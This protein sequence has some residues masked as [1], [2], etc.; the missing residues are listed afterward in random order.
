MAHYTNH[1]F[2]IDELLTIDQQ[3]ED[4]IESVNI[5]LSDPDLQVKDLALLL[6]SLEIMDNMEH[7]SGYKDFIIG[8]AEKSS[9][10]VT[11][12]EMIENGG[13]DKTFL[14]DNLVQNA[15]FES[16]A[17]EFEIAKASNFDVG[18]DLAS[19]WEN[20][21]AYKFDK[22]IIEGTTL[23]SAVTDGLQTAVSGF[24]VAL[25]PN[26]QYK[27]EYDLLVN[28]VNWDL[29]NGGKNLVDVPSE[30]TTIFSETGGGPDPQTYI[31][32]VI[33]DVNLVIPTCT[34][35]A[36]TI[37][38]SIITELTC[39]E[40]NA[41]WDYNPSTASFFCNDPNNLAPGATTTEECS[42]NNATWDEGAL[43]DP[44]TQLHTIVP[45][46]V[47]AREGDTIIFTNP[48]GNWLLHNAVSDDNISF[49]SP[50]LQP[51]ED[52]SWVVDG[53]HD[54]YFHCTFHPLEEGRLSTTT[55]HR[56]VYNVGHG[57]NTGDTIRVPINYGAMV[58][59]PNLANSYYI[60]ISMTNNVSSI[61]GAGSQTV[62]ESLYHDLSLGDLVT[63]QSGEV[64]DD[65]DSTP[66]VL[67]GFIG[68]NDTPALASATIAAGSISAVTLVDGGSG[69]TEAP[70]ILIEG[71]GG[72]GA[73]AVATYS[74][75]I[76]S[77]ALASG[78]GYT[79]TPSISF[80]G[81]NPEVGAVATAVLGSNVVSALVI[82]TAGAGYTSIP[83]VTITG[84][85]AVQSATATAGIDFASGACSDGITAD[86]TEC[87]T[88]VCSNGIA[89]TEDLCAI[90][91]CSN[92]GAEVFA[93][94]G[95]TPLN[96]AQCIVEICSDPTYTDEA[97]CVAALANWA[98]P[99][100]WTLA[101]TWAAPGT[102]TPSD[103]TLVSIAIINSGDQY[104]T[105]PTVTITGG[106]ASVDA[107]VSA[108]IGAP[109]DSILLN[110][111]GVGYLSTPSIEFT[112]GNPTFAGSASA[113]MDGSVDTLTLTAGGTGYGSATGEVS[114]GERQW[115]TYVIDAV[116]KGS[117]RVDVYFNDVNQIGH[118]HTAM[119]T[120]AQYA[121][122]QTGTPTQVSTISDST[123]HEHVATFD[124]DPAINDGAG[125]LLLVGM[126][127]G[128]THGLNEYFEISG[129][130][131]VELVNFGHYH[132]ILINETDE[133]TLKANLIVPN[134]TNGDG[135][136]AHDGTGTVM[137]RTSDFGTSD[138]Q[139]FHTVEFGCV[140]AV[141]D[142]YA[143]TV[144]DQHIHDFGRVWYPGSDQFTIGQYDNSYN[145]GDDLNP[146][147]IANPFTDIPGFVKK[148]R[149]ILSDDHGLVPGDRV[150]FENVYN[151]I[152]HGNT[153]Y[154]ID[155]V[156][157][158]DSFVLTETVVY[159]LEN[160]PGTTPSTFNVIEE[161][162]VAADLASYRFQV[163]RDLTN[164]IGDSVA[165][166]GVQLFWS[167]PNAVYS[168]AHGLNIGDVVQLPSGPQQYVPSEI[169]GALRDHTVVGLGD[170]YGPTEHM[171][172]TV[173]TQ[174][175]ITHA[176][177][178][179]PTQ[180]G[181][182]QT[183]WY[184]T[185]WDH[186]DI[187]YF[188]YQRPGADEDTFGDNDGTNG[189][190]VLHRGGSYRFTNNAWNPSGHMI[191]VDPITGDN[192]PMYMHA[193]GIK[194]ITGGGWDN[195]A[196]PGFAD[197]ANGKHC[198]SM[199][200]NHGLTINVGDHND[201]IN[202][203]EQPGTWVGPEAF[204][205]CMSLSG[206]CEEID[207]DGWYYNGEDNRVACEALNPTNDTGLAQW[208]EAQFIGN[209]SKEFTWTIPEDYGLSGSDGVTGLGPFVPPGELNGAYYLETDGGLYKFDKGGM[210]EGTNR[211]LNFYRGG[212]YRFHINAPGHDLYITT[213]SGTNFIEGAWFGEYTLGVTGSRAEY[214]SQASQT[215]GE[216]C[217]NGIGANSAD[218]IADGGVWLLNNFGLDDAGLPKYE[219]L[220]FTVSEYAPDTLYYQC[221]WH[222]SM[223]GIINIL[224]M[225]VT[226]A[227]ED[228]VVYFHHGQD[229]MYTPIH[230]QDKIA[231]DNG[232]GPNYFQV[233][234]VPENTFP[235]AGTIAHNN[236]TG[237][238]LS[239]AG[240]G[241]VPRVEAMN[242]EL[243]TEQWMPQAQMTAGYGSET[244]LTTGDFT[245][246][247]LFYIS[248]DQG[249][250][251]DFSLHNV[252]LSES[253]WTESGSF[254]VSLATAFVEDAA[255]GGTLSQIVTGSVTSGVDYELSYDIIE[256]FI[257]EYGVET[258]TIQGE[259]IGD[260][261]VSGLIN[262]AVGSYTE[263]LT[264][265]LNT[266]VLK[267]TATGAGKID[268]VSLKERVTGQNAWYFGEGWTGSNGTALASGIVQSQAEISQ[269]VPVT[270]GSLYEIQ[271]KLADTDPQGDGMQG[272]LSVSLGT[273]PY[274]LITNWNFD[275]VASQVNWTSSASSI[276]FSNETLVFT[277]ANYDEVIYTFAENLNNTA[278]YEVVIDVEKVAG[279]IHQFYVDGN[280]SNHSHT[281]ELSDAQYA[282]L[283]ENTGET[284][285]VQQTDDQH[286]HL[287]TH[288]FTLHHVPSAEFCTW[289]M[290]GAVDT[291]NQTTGE[292]I[293]HAGDPLW[294]HPHTYTSGFDVFVN[295]KNGTLAEADMTML[296]QTD[297]LVAGNCS[298]PALLDQTACE[299]QYCSDPLYS[300]Q[301]ACED[302]SGVWTDGFEWTPTH[303]HNI[304]IKYNQNSQVFWIS[305][306]D[307]ETHNHATFENTSTDSGIRIVTQTFWEGHDDI[308]HTGTTVEIS[309]VVF[310][311]GDNNN[312]TQ[313]TV[314]LN[315]V[316]IYNITLPG[317][318][319][320][321]AALK[322]KGSGIINS[323]RLTERQV[324][325][326]DHYTTGISVTGIQ[327]EYVRAGD[328]DTKIH[329]VGNV[330]KRPIEPD[331]PFYYSRG[332]QGSI[333]DVSVMLVEE[334]WT[335]ISETDGDS[336]V[337]QP[338]GRI[339]TVGTGPNNRG[340]AH[341]SFAVTEGYHY[342]FYVDVDR[343]TASTV[344]VGP[345][346]DD[347]QY[348]L[349][350]IADGSTDVH[351]DFVFTADATG[352]CYLTLATKGAGFT[353]WDNVSVKT[354]PN[355]TSD[356]YLLLGRAL[357]V[358]GMPI[359][360]EERWKSQHLDSENLDYT[361]Q[362]LSGFRT[363]ESYGENIVETYYDAALRADDL[364]DNDETFL[365]VTWIQDAEA[366]A[367]HSVMFEGTGFTSSMT[368]TIGGVPQGLAI[369]HLPTILG[370]VVDPATP[371]V[372]SD[373]V[374]TNTE[375]E[376]S[377]TIEGAFTRIL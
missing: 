164:H 35:G 376:E 336:Y 223:M 96:E 102:W 319:G 146:T 143:I 237:N 33:E 64:E 75:V 278:S 214:N 308:A 251:S 186:L 50:D 28:A 239:A 299:A 127:G 112:G 198:I 56:Y 173:D 304:K 90:N 162:T 182:Q 226:N 261:D 212:T 227:G 65:E 207:V 313:E 85:G 98:A 78:A 55:N 370:F 20:G 344:K 149:G 345:A 260:T 254:Q 306:D 106:G 153:N 94:D 76:D 315:E 298:D 258:G 335:F 321:K 231:I 368:L 51:G 29:P 100:T 32:S 111:P 62:I 187:S 277:D 148:Q 72:Y 3:K 274:N 318:I 154:W 152:H 252:K 284:L 309:E 189:G 300:E 195:L 108:L 53:Y 270:P 134:G 303:A 81:G 196:T 82:D 241:I 247:A 249:E 203:E 145:G 115:E 332:F 176:D 361:G 40:D 253:P 375:T 211:T 155:S 123:G 44:T 351:R 37:D 240:P 15:G 83:T 229:N 360:G 142:I 39:L 316:G 338:T 312:W 117:E 42:A 175:T 88:I 243:G 293:S 140:D 144:I 48:T 301:T 87:I 24:D 256:P 246:D 79:S 367:G 125:G 326:I 275:A 41:W 129:G 377:V 208:R 230:I 352:I 363:M 80:I 218:C 160:A 124:W 194:E 328:Y 228:V 180:E 163:E 262:T 139:H 283:K 47:N 219:V 95:T 10:F 267:L 159:P 26:T 331:S 323:V 334:K 222:E 346:P 169:P 356:E 70:S 271:Y 225:P 74:A 324:P 73:T 14:S 46:H 92:N 248:L 244:F 11:P 132:E 210:I 348:A 358:F 202:V 120:P 119:L 276:A 128:H 242:I 190:F 122:I 279:V 373:F 333:D 114:F 311:L 205:T 221:V 168:E 329:F 213:D 5:K 296:S 263:T 179:Q 295:L 109:I 209:F 49:A 60:N 347:S 101:G 86:E 305:D 191:I 161:Y 59:L 151:G 245:G 302:N 369:I 264:A 349:F 27:F 68:Q 291:V 22:L 201:F 286:A 359:G 342:K 141:N 174:A 67:I 184:W 30:D 350:D 265:P 61:G 130:T 280:I 337:D 206:W 234:P 6:K 31:C 217:H 235:V 339:V 4:F 43:N 167:R 66:D 97:T 116:Q 292:I 204:P 294:D 126:S 273:N 118:I 317:A 18:I 135:T 355:L 282:Y 84:G 138:P 250:R 172:I 89:Q 136:T 54:L 362:V 357:N 93:A 103:G 104:Q 45:Y 233:L 238:L 197:P 69:Y 259:L 216:K 13:L 23:V 297:N 1:D 165:G 183:P 330:D 327:T 236:D 268:N 290:M 255:I 99:G 52:W 38:A 57:L 77:I 16:D 272:R 365:T 343:P 232:S 156:V 314:M 181:A 178:N 21:I 8:V 170:G 374:L 150:H 353:Y 224:D 199:R 307:S 220:E 185:W 71:G 91:H 215:D 177:P 25:K 131:K 340:I 133:A 110:S 366:V 285:T 166:T 325:A 171:E 269:T 121:T 107:T 192:I 2:N 12:I 289:L 147:V 310:M 281:A 137:V 157:T 372:A 200:A 17:M 287:Y 371:L 7:L 257:D 193:A 288:T 322:L 9:D 320:N 36:G 34:T 105:A 113:T 158:K 364:M 341:I 58:A 188:P 354:I 63:M 19:P 266:T